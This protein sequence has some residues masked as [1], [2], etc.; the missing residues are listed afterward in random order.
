MT[1]KH[2]I[3]GMEKAA[4]VETSDS[5]SDE[6]QTI[7]PAERW[8]LVAEK[9]YSLAQR[10]GFVG[11]DPIAEWS[12]A[13]REVDATYNS[14]VPGMLSRTDAEKMSEYVKSEF[15]GYG[16]G[17]LGLDALLTKHREGLEQLTEHHRRMLDSTTQ[18]AS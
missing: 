15:G 17:Y 11:G 3:S 13:Q 8:L 2:I 1:T 16:L 9:A 4:Q 14:A 10:R 7:S 5:P 6:K 18:L 12:E